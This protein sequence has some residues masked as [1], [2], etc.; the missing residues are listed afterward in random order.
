MSGCVPVRLMELIS[1]LA[2]AKDNYSWPNPL[3]YLPL[4]VFLYYSECHIMYN[5]RLG[6]RILWGSRF[7]CLQFRTFIK[8]YIES[9]LIN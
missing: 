7:L 3:V 8:N 2:L 4:P 6:R 1:S 5:I 9:M